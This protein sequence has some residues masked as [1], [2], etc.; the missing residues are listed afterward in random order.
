MEHQRSRNPL[1]DDGIVQQVLLILGEGSYIYAQLNKQWREAYKRTALQCS[2]AYSNAFSS[3]AC[4]QLC[5]EA[6]FE[7]NS[8]A[9]TSA[10]GRHASIDVLEAAHDLGMK[11]S[12]CVTA[13]AATEAAKLDWLYCEKSCPMHRLL[14]LGESF[15]VPC[16]KQAARFSSIRVLDL[17]HATGLRADPLIMRSAGAAATSQPLRW[18]FSRNYPYESSAA[19]A[20]AQNRSL[21]VLQFLHSSADVPEWPA[22]MLTGLLQAAGGAGRIDNCRW[23]RQQGADWPDT[24]TW[25]LQLWPAGSIEWAREEGCDAPAA[26]QLPDFDWLQ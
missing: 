18:L 19:Y 9:A 6:G 14:D 16:M 15:S 26:L 2:T 24:L 22:H 21:E 5:V 23:L 25:Q 20:A 1:T 7:V 13:G 10:A 4:L 11:W 12:C 3:I 8:E 17:L